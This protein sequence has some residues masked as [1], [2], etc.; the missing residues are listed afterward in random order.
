MSTIAAVRDRIA[1]LIAAIN[2]V[3][4]PDDRYVESRN[5]TDGSFYNWCEGSPTAAFRRFQVRH[6]GVHP[7][8]EIGDGVTE[9]LRPTFLISVC[10]PQDH[11]AGI[12]QAISRDELMEADWQA[13]NKAAGLYARGNFFDSHNATVTSPPEASR[14]TGETCDY[15]VITQPMF[16]YRTIL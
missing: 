13:I 7:T 6:D 15:L 16:L 1:E 11:R 8:I 14:L 5:E 4:L 12:E 2:P 9:G 10:Y 3:N